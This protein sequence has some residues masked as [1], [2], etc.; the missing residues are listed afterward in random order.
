MLLSIHKFKIYLYYVNM[1]SLLI[2]IKLIYLE[3]K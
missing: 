3:Y 2:K 1:I